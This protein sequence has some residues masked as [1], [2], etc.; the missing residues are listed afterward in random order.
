MT[1][2][3]AR[4]STLLIGLLA[5]PAVL[6]AAETAG[7][8][9]ERDALLALLEEQ[10]AIATKTRLNA[11]YVPGIVTVLH[12][13]ELEARGARTVWEALALVP[14]INPVID[15]TGRKQLIVRGIGDIYNSSNVKILLNDVSLSNMKDGF[16]NPAM[17]IPVEQIERIEVI[18]GPGSA[19]HGEFAYS[20][21]IN[22]ITRQEGN[23]VYVTAGGNNTAGGGVL[24]SHT[25]PDDD[26]R[27]SLNLAGWKTDG[28]VDDSGTDFNYNNIS[29]ALSYSPGPSNEAM[30]AG[31]AIFNLHYRDFSLV[32]QW[33]RDGI[34]D[35]F[36]L[37]N[38]LPPDSNRIV[39]RNESR[40]VDISQKLPAAN[41]MDITIAAGWRSFQI[42][43]D[44]QYLGLYP[45][46]T[47]AP[48]LYLYSMYIE[49]E[50]HGGLNLE[51]SPRASHRLF[52]S[53]WHSEATIGESWTEVQPLPRE[54]INE[55]QQRRITS[56]TLQDEYRHSEIFTLTTGLRYD[57]YSDTDDN[58]APRISGVW[59]LS[60][61]QIIKLQ[62]AH[63]F[64]APN[65]TELNYSNGI[66]PPTVDTYEL[67]IIHKQ[68]HLQA[69]ATLYYS[70]M[71][72]L[73]ITG[74]TSYL[75]TDRVRTQGFELEGKLMVTSKL[76]FD[77]NISYAD[78]RDDKTGKAV[79][80]S[81]EWM[82]N[83][84]TTFRVSNDSELN[85]Q[86][87]YVSDRSREASDTRDE[88]D[89]YSN[90]DLTLSINN[91]GHQD[92]TVRAGI[93]NLLDTDIFYPA[94]ANTYINDYPRPGRT[95]WLQASY[96]Y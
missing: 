24:L 27:M 41:N 77:G 23:Q 52:T 1:H 61:Q 19:V 22:I 15:A 57:S 44:Q 30:D 28:G 55:G 63:A 50:V 78:T 71:D 73:I 72:N 91:A 12:G 49:N 82:S 11:D 39:T 45:P 13:S 94:P 18:R 86:Y 96:R 93:K 21:L 76:S 20:G 5:A 33:N 53:L 56:I 84:G 67:G 90:I 34:G 4:I 37:N 66:R 35:H 10:T 6:I 88:L 32:A 59:R 65:F 48:Y 81:A 68:S 95:W 87:R 62:Y 2:D 38:N 17:N 3:T 60:E 42:E 46:L 79:F 29:P 58:L 83:I 9:A 36:G 74:P 51:W 89:A 47:P 64:R 26:F 7:N 25:R 75:N 54:Y 8:G 70:A 40:T 69:R 43:R 80:G 31:S 85:L 92:L 14:G 16:A